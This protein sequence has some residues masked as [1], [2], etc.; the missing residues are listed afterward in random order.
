M[1]RWAIS[2][3]APASVARPDAG[4]RSRQSC[5]HLAG[6]R[7]AD[8]GVLPDRLCAGVSALPGPG[9][10]R[11]HRL[12]ARGCRL[13]QRFPRSRLAPGDCVSDCWGALNR[14][15]PL[16]DLA[17]ADFD[18]R[19]RNRPFHRVLR[20]DGVLRPI[21]AV[22]AMTPESTMIRSTLLSHLPACEMGEIAPL[23]RNLVSCRTANGP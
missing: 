14:A 13:K 7:H 19:L 23:S 9:V 8:G 6:P 3:A 4:L 20:L 1:L 5:R 17:K 12:M 2:P 11:R 18:H 15:V 21:S 16:A 22:K 10:S